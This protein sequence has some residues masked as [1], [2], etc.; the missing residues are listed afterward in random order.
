MFMLNIQSNIYKEFK[1]TY[2]I[3]QHSYVSQVDWPLHVKKLNKMKS[4]KALAKTKKM[5]LLF[6]SVSTCTK[7]II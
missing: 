4:I 6:I 5:I 2:F 1:Y 7:T 3:E